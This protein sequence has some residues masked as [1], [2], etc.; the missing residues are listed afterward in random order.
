[1][2]PNASCARPGPE[3]ASGPGPTRDRPLESLGVG[4]ASMIGTAAMA[5]VRQG[6][7]TESDDEVPEISVVMPCL[8]ESET[9]ATCI[10]KAFATFR[11]HGIRGEVIVADNGSTDGSQ[12]LACEHGARVVPIAARGYGNALMG[13]IAAARGRYVVMGD[14]DDSYDFRHVPRF[15]EKLREGNDLVMGNR[16]LGGIEPGAMPP[17]H[18]YF[19][20][21]LLTKIARC[22]FRCP[23]GDIYCGL[24]GFRKDSNEALQLRT[25]GME[26]ACE[27]V[28]KATLQ[29]QKIAEIPTT[30]SPDGRSRA[31]HLRSWRD[32]WRTLRFMLLYSPRW[33]FLYPGL[34]LML[35]GV[36]LFVGPLLASRKALD[37]ATLR[38]L[39]F[40]SG[41][42]LMGF[43]SA[44]FAMFSKI[45]ALSSGLHPPRRFYDRLFEIFTL[46]TG[47]AVGGTLLTL[48]CAGAAYST[49]AWNPTDGAL[50][51]LRLALPSVV[52]I[53]LGFE[54]ILSS[55][56]LSLAGLSRT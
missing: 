17:L 44:N 48:G 7:F 31:P 16:F 25:T 54:M 5:N 18:R 40:A 8:N 11:E 50:S 51:A 42:V 4:T 20:N 29:G 53:I 33:L 6:L 10:D 49:W 22:F 26:Y 35:L 30:L 45:F 12:R 13:G 23:I 55:F 19:G 52:A 46:E 9:L 32:G 43:Q 14:S 2:D 24:R 34:A 39:L 38:Q 27:M 28:I 37:V 41:M 3:A 56:L 21:P 36:L 15:L 47:L 1:M